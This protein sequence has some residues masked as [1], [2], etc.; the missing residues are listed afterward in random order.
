MGG[1]RDAVGHD[2][3]R[4]GRRQRGRRRLDRRALVGGDARAQLA[5]DGDDPLDLGERLEPAGSCRLRPERG[6]A[7][8]DDLDLL[9]ERVGQGQHDGVEAALERRRQVVDALVAVVGGGDDVEALLGLHLVVELGDRQVLLR[10]DRDEG[11]LHVGRDAGQ[12]LDADE[13]P[14]SMARI[15][16]LG[17]SAARVGPSASSRA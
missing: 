5:E 15:T 14:V 6:D 3:D 16:G 8:A 11:V 2:R 10:Q 7:G 17:T 4:L 9:L 13:R 1:Q 12:L